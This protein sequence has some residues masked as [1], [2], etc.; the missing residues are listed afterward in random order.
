MWRLQ[1]FANKMH[2]D[3]VP[4]DFNHFRKIPQYLVISFIQYLTRSFDIFIWV[5]CLFFDKSDL[6]NELKYVIFE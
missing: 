2:I 4:I 6:K 5:K 3:D 1:K